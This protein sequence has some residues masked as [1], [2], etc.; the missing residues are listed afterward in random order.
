MR[1]TAA[2]F[3]FKRIAI[4][5]SFRAET[6]RAI[7]TTSTNAPE[8]SLKPEVVTETGISLPSLQSRIASQ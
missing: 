1:L 2:S 7:S 8:E 4:S 5:A 3:S 6:S